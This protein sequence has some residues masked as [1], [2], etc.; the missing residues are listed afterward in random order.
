MQSMPETQGRPLDGVLVR[1]PEDRVIDAGDLRAKRGKMFD[2]TLA[3]SFPASDPP[4]SLPDPWEEDSF[5]I[6]T[7]RRTVE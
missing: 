6:K 3:D 4:S 2:K 1:D 5:C 7:K